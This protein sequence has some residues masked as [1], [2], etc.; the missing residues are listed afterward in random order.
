MARLIAPL[1]VGLLI[2]APARAV[3]GSPGVFYLERAGERC[4][5]RVFDLKQRT[6][7]S[8]CSTPCPWALAF[9]LGAR[10][11]LYSVG[12]QVFESR[13]TPPRFHTLPAPP[14]G[15]KAREGIERVWLDAEGVVRVA[16][17]SPPQKSALSRKGD[18]D[19]YRFEGKVIKLEDDV[20]FFGGMA[21]GLKLVGQRWIRVEARPS[22]GGPD[23]TPT[24]AVLKDKQPGAGTYATNVY[25]QPAP[26]MSSCEKLIT[27]SPAAAKLVDKA[28]AGADVRRVEHLPF[29][30]GSGLLACATGFGNSGP[31]HLC[32]RSCLH[33]VKLY[34]M[35]QDE[36]GDVLLSR[37]GAHAWI[38]YH[39]DLLVFDD[40]AELRPVLR[41][42]WPRAFE[43]WVLIPR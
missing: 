31:V 29:G 36:M 11:Y 2:P 32:R 17:L 9:D 14:V 30:Q 5:W 10:R 21:I 43:T 8:I 39:D 16:H 38:R 20:A 27:A 13:G 3:E 42:R 41:L 37:F 22:F 25:A 26:A 7:R 18:S 12:A 40:S 35:G 24:V 34:D 28:Y 19:Y 4:H 33:S 15:S 6:A 23:E 1:L